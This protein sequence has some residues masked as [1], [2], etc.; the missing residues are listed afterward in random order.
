M[1][2]GSGMLGVEADWERELRIILQ[3]G[4]AGGSER[5]WNQEPVGR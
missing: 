3:N 2:E 4:P 5:R 1:G